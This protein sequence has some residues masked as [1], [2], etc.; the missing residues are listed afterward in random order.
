MPHRISSG[1][2]H[3]LGPAGH[4]LLI[5][6]EHVLIRFFTYELAFSGYYYPGTTI[7]VLLSGYYYP[8]TRGS[9]PVERAQQWDRFRLPAGVAD[10]PPALLHS[11]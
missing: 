9:C 11:V 6:E 10:Q 2:F 4:G 7:R 1:H 8:G 5:P 3:V